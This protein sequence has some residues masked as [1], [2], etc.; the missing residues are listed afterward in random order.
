MSPNSWPS[1][2]LATPRSDAAATEPLWSWKTAR[3]DGDD[4]G[5]GDDDDKGGAC[6]GDDA[7]AAIAA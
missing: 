3:D 7:A 2:W 5:N 6:D 4:D 1:W